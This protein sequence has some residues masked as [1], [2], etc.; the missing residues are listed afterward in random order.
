VEH[1][2]TEP[3]DCDAH[4]TPQVHRYA[5]LQVVPSRVRAAPLQ[6]ALGGLDSG[7]SRHPQ[8]VVHPGRTLGLDR[9]ESRRSSFP[10]KH[11]SPRSLSAF[12]G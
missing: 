4:C 2:T 11:S 8:R 7:H 3:H 12:R 5:R 9:C 10:A 6:A 1:R